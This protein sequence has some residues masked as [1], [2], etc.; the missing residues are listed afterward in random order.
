[1]QD[2][3]PEVVM[4]AKCYSDLHKFRSYAL[5]GKPQ[6]QLLRHATLYRAIAMLL[7]LWC[8]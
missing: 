1:M 6:A 7:A 4:A 5:I 3:R 2:G 8:H